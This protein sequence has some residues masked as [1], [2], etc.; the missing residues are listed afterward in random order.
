MDNKDKYTI[1]YCPFCDTEQVI[2][3][4][5]IT[6]C[7]NCGK[8]LAPCSMCETCDYDTCPYGCTGGEEDELK[9]ITNPKI[10]KDQVE[11][12]YRML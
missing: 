1:E 9:V 4:T 12:L 10:A 3:S 8:P 6:A 2:Y 5:G 7:P 11:K